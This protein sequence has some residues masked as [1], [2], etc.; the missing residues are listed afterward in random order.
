M[1]GWDRWGGGGPLCYRALPTPPEYA[2]V[3][4]GGM[5]TA[6][7]VGVGLLV[8]IDRKAKGV[9]RGGVL[10]H[11]DAQIVLHTL[12]KRVNVGQGTKLAGQLAD[13]SEAMV[14]RVAKVLN[15]IGVR[16][17]HVRIISYLDYRRKHIIEVWSRFLLHVGAQIKR[18]NSLLDTLGIPYLHTLG[19]A[20]L[21]VGETL[22]IG[23]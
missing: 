5:D 6:S 10:I 22:N 3:G 1:Q 11:G 15:R 13:R 4:V 21:H 23:G 20:C 14:A 7:G 18:E 12:A 9:L 8:P 2:G 17:S 19:I 16:C